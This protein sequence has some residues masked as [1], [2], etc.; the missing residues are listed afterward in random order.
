MSLSVSNRKFFWVD[1]YDVWNTDLDFANNFDMRGTVVSTKTVC[2]SIIV[3]FRYSLLLNDRKWW[4]H[5]NLADADLN[6]MA[7]YWLQHRSNVKVLLAMPRVGNFLSK[8][9]VIKQVGK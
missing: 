3:H 7:V 1:L 5:I 6:V 9:R 8:F 4:A 2:G